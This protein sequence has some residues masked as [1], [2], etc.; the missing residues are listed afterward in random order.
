M[1]KKLLPLVLGVLAVA[2]IVLVSVGYN[3]KQESSSGVTLSNAVVDVIGSQSGTTTT[4]VYFSSS[5]NFINYPI[6]I[7]S[8]IDTAVYSVSA[9]D[10]STTAPTYLNFLASNDVKCNTSTTTGSGVL[11]SDINWFDA[12]P[13]LK[14]FTASTSITGGPLTLTFTPGGANKNR[15]YVLTD[16]NA[17]C[18]AIKVAA[19][20]TVLRVQLSTK[21]R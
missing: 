18:L 11:A 17:K 19:S 3:P 6:F 16:L 14:D 12:S 8:D 15:E 4:G 21:Q 13:H 9:K 7:G 1:N 10:A 5:T 20:S 2:L